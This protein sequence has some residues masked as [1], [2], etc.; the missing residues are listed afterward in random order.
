MTTLRVLPNQHSHTFRQPIESAAHVRCFAGHPDPRPLRAIHR[1]EARQ[2]DHPAAS[3]TASNA[4]TCSASNPGLTIRLRPFFR[5]ISTPASRDGL[6]TPPVTCTSR[7][8]PGV[9]S[10][11]RFFHTKKYGRHKPC[12]RQNVYLAGDGRTPGTGGA[13]CKLSGFG[14][15][16]LSAQLQNPF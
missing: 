1:L 5:R 11:T 15:H 3:T 14:F 12:S 9:P 2:P 16:L 4:R 6:G 13:D 7:N 10:C 8:F